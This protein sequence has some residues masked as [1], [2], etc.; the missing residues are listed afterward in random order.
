MLVST[1]GLGLGVPAVGSM[2]GTWKA[3]SDVGAFP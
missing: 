3:C 2:C 1:S